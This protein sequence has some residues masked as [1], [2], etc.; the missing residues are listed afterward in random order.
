MTIMTVEETLAE[1]RRRGLRLALFGTALNLEM[2]AVLAHLEPLGS[3]KGRDGGIYEV[4]IFHNV[5]QDWLVVVVETG[6]GTHSAQSA[7]TY[8]HIEFGFEIQIF[9]G[10]GG[11]RKDDVPIG[12]VVAAD[13][14]Y[15]PYV[16]KYGEEGYSGP[17]KGISNSYENSGHCPQGSPRRNLGEPDQENCG[18]EAVSSRR[19][20]GCTSTAQFHR[21]RG[22]N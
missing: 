19:I 8:A 15:F 5:D 3:V 18:V 1:A 13:H 10:V 7:V 2:K 12:S 16:G 6:A 21:T 22:V 11:S 4:G 9:V 17:A 14:V 20:P